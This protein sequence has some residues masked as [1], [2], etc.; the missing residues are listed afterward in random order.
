MPDFL[1]ILDKAANTAKLIPLDHV[2][3]IDTNTVTQKITAAAGAPAPSATVV[4]ELGD[5]SDGGIFRAV[6]TS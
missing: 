3:H 4:L 5:M 2:A 1:R 6:M